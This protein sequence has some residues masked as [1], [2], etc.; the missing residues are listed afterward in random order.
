MGL[1]LHLSSVVLDHL[2]WR[3]IGGNLSHDSK[4]TRD[5]EAKADRKERQNRCHDCA[6]ST[7][8]RIM[9]SKFAKK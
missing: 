5:Q 8:D 6:L 3:D 4:R 1:Q 9:S 2:S 7:I